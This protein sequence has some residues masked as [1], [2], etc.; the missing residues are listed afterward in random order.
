MQASHRG[1]LVRAC[2]PGASGMGL[3][4]FSTENAVLDPEHLA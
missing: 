1:L 2:G 3:F 4:A